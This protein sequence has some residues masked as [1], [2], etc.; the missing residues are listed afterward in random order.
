MNNSLINHIKDSS[1]LK[2]QELKRDWLRDIGKL[3]ANIASLRD[4]LTCA[5]LELQARED[6]KTQK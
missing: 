1:D 4:A 5:D 3:E 6:K 2:I